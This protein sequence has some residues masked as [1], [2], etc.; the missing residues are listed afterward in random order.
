MV[1][2]TAGPYLKPAFAAAAWL[3]ASAASAANLEPPPFNVI[4]RHHV[5]LM[6]GTVAP[7]FTDLAIG[8]G[9]GL[10]H[11]VTTANSDFVNFEAGYGPLGPRDKFFG[12]IV[13]AIHHKTSPLSKDWVTVMRAVSF[14]GG[15]DFTINPGCATDSAGNVTYNTFASY[16][17]DPRHLL[18]YTADRRGLV[19][20]RPD[21]TRVV[22]DAPFTATNAQCFTVPFDT[23]L[24]GYGISRIEY[25]NGF[26]ISGGSA[27]NTPGEVK[28]N[29]GFQLTYVYVKRQEPDR[30]FGAPQEEQ[31]WA[32]QTLDTMW[33]TSVPTY[34]VAINNAVEYCA[35]RP[36]DFYASFEAACPGLTQAWPRVSY[37]WPVGMPRVAYLTDRTTT[38][39]ITDATGGVTRYVHKPFRSTLQ[40]NPTADYVPRLHEI[41]SARSDVTDITYDFQTLVEGAIDVG[42]DVVPGYSL[43]I[44]GPAAVLKG[45]VRNG[46]DQIGYTVG[47]PYGQGGMNINAA[48]GQD[49]NLSVKTNRTFGPF[50]ID[51][52]DKTVNFEQRLTNKLSNIYRKTDGVTLGYGY[53]SRYNVTQV[54][55]NGAV[56]Q[57]A[58]YPASCSVATRK[59]CN[60]PSWTKDGKN[61]QT[62]YSYDVNSGQVTRVRMPAATS[63]G[64]RPEIHYEYQAKYA[65]Y[66]R[67]AGDPIQKAETPVYLLTRERKCLAGAMSEDGSCASGETDAVV[68]DYDYGPA[69]APNNLL[70]RGVT[71]TAYSDGALQTRRSC[72]S[73]DIYGNRIGETRPQAGLTRCY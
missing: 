37:D 58:G 47:A 50:E 39:T 40:S 73:Y 14:D 35:A 9:L 70:L 45:S 68:T 3:L 55:E 60:Q 2:R 36:A 42:N 30:Y 21:G 28:T 15:H 64:I 10:S 8:G 38:F 43:Y 57:S 33:S 18:E 62:D 48:G 17:G 51:M 31:P 72:Y 5:N 56:V 26:T 24:Q 6:S 71:V 67:S 66:K 16:D 53:D 29:T 46:S 1:S 59:T 12:R 22:Y 41:Q 4:N 63:N 61:N 54:T 69:D 19:W 20:T 7:Q 49:G 25:P 44:A 23:E 34:V 13:K 32:P 52:W 65:Y 27:Q 11:W